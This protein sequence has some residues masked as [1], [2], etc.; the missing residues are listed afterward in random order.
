MGLFDKINN[1]IGNAVLGSAGI[2]VNRATNADV[3]AAMQAHQMGMQMASQMSGL[4]PNNIAT[5]TGRVIGFEQ[6]GAVKGGFPE[7]IIHMEVT[8]LGEGAKPPYPYDLTTVADP[9]EF[10]NAG[11]ILNLGT[12]P[13]LPG[14]FIR[15]GKRM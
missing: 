1:A 8:E 14:Q 7:I 5:A 15:L 6:T 4:H 3:N 12:V 13:E 2:E 11:D 10:P 9:S